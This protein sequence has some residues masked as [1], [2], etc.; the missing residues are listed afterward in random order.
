MGVSGSQGS[1]GPPQGSANDCACVISGIQQRDIVKIPKQN[2]DLISNFIYS[3]Y[4]LYNCNL[5]ESLPKLQVN[6]SKPFCRYF[7]TN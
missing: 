6:Q 4:T 7:I 2:I 1:L 3:I 5:Y